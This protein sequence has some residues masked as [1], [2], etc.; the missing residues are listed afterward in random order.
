MA[1]GE[2]SASG[3]K[4]TYRETNPAGRKAPAMMSK[5]AQKKFGITEGGG[6]TR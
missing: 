2:C 4:R 5:A 1:N 6:G 3:E